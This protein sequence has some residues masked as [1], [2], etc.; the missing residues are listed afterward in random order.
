MLVISTKDLDWNAKTRTFFVEASS[1]EGKYP[2]TRLDYENGEWFLHVRSHK[3]GKT[4]KFVRCGEIR[5]DDQVLV[6]VEFRNDEL[7]IMLGIAND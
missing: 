2:Q 5:E 4:M 6:A 1:L 7:G 3:T